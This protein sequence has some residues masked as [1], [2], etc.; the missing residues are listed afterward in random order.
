MNSEYIFRDKHYLAVVRGSLGE[1]NPARVDRI[2]GTGPVEPKRSP[3]ASKRVVS[4]CNKFVDEFDGLMDGMMIYVGWMEKVGERWGVGG[5]YVGDCQ[6]EAGA[7]NQARAGRERHPSELTL[8]DT[9][10]PQTPPSIQMF[11]PL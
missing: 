6:M 3:S 9:L 4:T 11:V 5:L 10:L 1:P 8:S 7:A 2:E